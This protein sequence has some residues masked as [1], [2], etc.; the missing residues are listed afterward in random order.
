MRLCEG[1]DRKARREHF[2]SIGPVEVAADQAH[3]VDHGTHRRFARTRARSKENETRGMLLEFAVPG[4]EPVEN[5]LELRA[6]PVVIERRRKDDDV[7]GE[8]SVDHAVHAVRIHVFARF[9]ALQEL[10]VDGRDAELIDVDPNDVG[11]GQFGTV[12]KAG[13]KRGRVAVEVGAAEKNR[14]FHAVILG[15]LSV[16]DVIG[17]MSGMLIEPFGHWSARS[18]PT[19]RRRASDRFLS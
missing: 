3:L 17:R 18:V 10:R 8:Q 9:E 7:G 6:H 14:D 19:V 2:A 12:R 4:E 15:F 5:D 1:F 13:R 16:A 11:T